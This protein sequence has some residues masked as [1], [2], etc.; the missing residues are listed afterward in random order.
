MAL[1]DQ[2]SG[3]VNRMI[4]L[5]DGDANHGVR[6][7]PGFRSIAQRA[8]S[9]GIP[10]TTIGVDVDFNEK[11][12]AA[13]AQESNGHHYFVANDSDLSRVFQAE[14][15]GLT[16]TVAS[17]AEIAIDLAPGVELD[18]VFD[19]SF[20]RSGNRIIVPLGTFAH[21]DVKTV[22]LKVRV[23]SQVEGTLAVAGVD[24][25]YRDLVGNTDGR[26]SG[27]LALEV[28]NSAGAG[29]L[30]PVVNGRVQ[31]SE[32]AATLK[33]ANSLFEQGKFGEARRKLEVQ[34][35][36]LREAAE[37][38][39]RAAP[40]AKAKDVADDFQ[41]QIAAIGTANSGFAQAPAAEPASPAFA[42]PPPGVAPV[43][44]A[45]FQAPQATRAGKSAV[46]ENQKRALDLGF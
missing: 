45:P 4:L 16:S 40:A 14:A 9:R 33:D 13:I 41:N 21:D 6:D 28:T 15:D 46:K 19:R 10:M 11:V 23:P 29:D 2:T 44:A 32:T 12:M 20:R 30:D 22:L 38:A 25:S 26:C 34:E 43:A 31:R 17:G 37:V 24:L 5:S 18:R 39:S 42:T 3:K 1:L 7:V 35:K 27:K 8:G 36:T